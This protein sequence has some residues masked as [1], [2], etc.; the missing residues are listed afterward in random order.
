MPIYGWKLLCGAPICVWTLP[1][2]TVRAGIHIRK[3]TLRCSKDPKGL[4]NQKNSLQRIVGTV[5]MFSK[6]LGID[7][8]TMFTRLADST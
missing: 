6:D 7:L 5:A 2:A 8:G 1:D 4:K 3:K